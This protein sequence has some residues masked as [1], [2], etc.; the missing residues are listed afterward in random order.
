MKKT[1]RRILGIM[2]ACL[3]ICLP[4]MQALAQTY[5]AG[6][7]DPAP[8]LFPGDELTGIMTPVTLDGEPVALGEGETSWTNDSEGK[9]Y[10]AAAAED[11]SVALTLAGYEL[12]VTGGTSVAAD[13][14]AGP[15]GGHYVPAEDEVVDESAPKT[16]RAYYPAYTIVK[17]K[18]DEPEEG[19]EFEKWTVDSED[20]ILED[21]LNSE[22]TV[23]LPEKKVSIT[24][25]YRP[26]QTEAD[27]GA[28]GEVTDPN[29]EGAPGEV[30]DPNAADAP[31]EVTDP[32]AAGEPDGNIDMGVEGTPI[33]IADPNGAGVPDENVD[34]GLEGTPVD[35]VD[36]NGAGAPDGNVDPGLEGAPVDG[37]DP[38]GAG[39]P[40]EN[41]DPGLE[42][43]PI[44]EIDLGGGNATDTMMPG[45][46]SAIIVT[47]GD[48]YNSE[49]V[50]TLDVYYGTVGNEGIAGTE[51]ANG[52]G[53]SYS[54]SA[55]TE[56]SVSANDYTI[57]GFNFS[58]WD[59]ESGNVALTPAENTESVSFT[60]PEGDVVITA[61]YADAEGNPVGTPQ[62]QPN[63]VDEADPTPAPTIDPTPGPI[64][65]SEN[66]I[67]P[68]DETPTPPA[69]HS[70]TVNCGTAK[71][72][73]GTAST[74][75]ATGTQVTIT[76]A[77]RTAE[78]LS[79]NGWTVDSGNTTLANAALTETT[80]T[81]PDAD[82]MI[83]AN[84]AQIQTE[85]TPAPAYGVT[86]SG[87]VIT[88]TG[89]ASGSFE[90]GATVQLQANAPAAGMKFVKWSAKT[91]AGEAIADS[92]FSAVG[93]ATTNFVVPASAVT[94]TAEFAKIEYTITVNDGTANYAKAGSDTKVR[95][96]ADE[97]PEGME[98]DYWKVDSGNVT[99]RNAS[100]AT[101][102]FL[103]PT[104]DVEVSAY[105]RMKEYHVTVQ[106]GHA[107]EDTYYMGQEV[108]IYSNY[109]SSGREFDQW[110]K[111]SGKVTFGDATRWK[112]TFTMPAS[113][114][115]VSAAYKD[116]PAPSSNQV[117]DLVAGGEYITDN[118][119]KFT[120]A[121]AG[122]DNS[123]PNPGDYRYRP[124]GYQIGNVT[125]SWQSAPY[126]T[127]M[128][129][130]A[131][132]DYTLK[133]N[134]SKDVFDGTNWVPDGT[135]DT[136]SVTFRVLT[137]AEAV[138][139]GDETPIVMM[140]IL[141]GA[142]CLLFLLLLSVF[143]R[144]RS[145]N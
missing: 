136:R 43:T 119:I 85:P 12:D 140:V 122:M 34:P 124:T 127:S 110:Q 55:G 104:A 131:R 113:D 84:Y 138:K 53:M 100:K 83:T 137:P 67:A 130:K 1:R 66:S 70:V 39:A 144:R 97:A 42:G 8:I 89:I 75:F 9:V 88:A 27:P 132:G 37:V 123:N 139:T 47:T 21:E 57:N 71:G 59:N 3:M 15:L 94:V 26:I 56:V 14:A 78:N 18:A 52:T 121:G 107:D 17:I 69:T 135:T 126:T 105:Y 120:A 63:P 129:I 115:T 31:G 117:L 82:V 68:I 62:Y 102:S 90:A 41:V 142:S 38:N 81:M 7:M 74:T 35:G 111:V 33:E 13:K 91:E 61:K 19:M 36:P 45:D 143:I 10:S 93:E 23:T 76:A 32:N 92:A 98:F 2:M 46:P 87:G 118:T 86:V 20:V 24:A 48:T 95:I 58:Y 16:D 28:G 54:I 145:R 79:F 49:G 99:L 72:P 73:D 103:M 128:S 50:Y 11:G 40:D 5:D 114:V 44:D 64:T 77:D 106:N 80:F 116:G 51:I 29:A 96:T 4:A 60:M 109:P 108:T 125:G 141:A 25:N 112:T 6:V 101:T 22:T 30:I 65:G 133:V 134:Y